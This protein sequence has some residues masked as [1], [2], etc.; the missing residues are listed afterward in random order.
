MF[1]AVSHTVG[2]MQTS[3]MS[4]GDL[5]RHQTSVQTLL[6]RTWH[7][8]EWMSEVVPLVILILNLAIGGMP[9]VLHGVHARPVHVGTLLVDLLHAMR[10]DPFARSVGAVVCNVLHGV[11]RP[12]AFDATP[13]GALHDA[14]HTAGLMG[15]QPPCRD[16]RRHASVGAFHDAEGAL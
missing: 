7:H 1:H 12:E 6:K 11:P 8:L 15:R 2:H 5:C 14:I 3:V 16:V 10:V 13:Q 4:L 9:I